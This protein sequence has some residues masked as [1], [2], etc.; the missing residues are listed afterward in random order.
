VSNDERDP[1]DAVLASEGERWRSAQATPPDPD[2][3]RLGAASGGPSR[4]TPVAAVAAVLAVIAAIG[5][6]AALNRG[7]AANP[8]SSASTT[9]ARPGPGT[10]VEG[11]GVLYRERG[12]PIR[13]CAGLVSTADGAMS[14]TGCIAPEVETTGV[15]PALLTTRAG[16]GADFSASV[17]VEGTHHKGVL[18]VTR[19]E[20]FQGDPGR[21]NSPL[22]CPAP[23]E[24]WK[25][26][27][28]HQPLTGQDDAI[29]QANEFVLAN[30]DRFSG[31][32]LTHPVIIPVGPGEPSK[33]AVVVG[34]TG[35]VDQVRDELLFY[36]G[37]LCVFKVRYSKADLDRLADQLRAVT[38]IPLTVDVDEVS[39]KVRVRTVVL[40]PAAMAVLDRF[41]PGALLVEEPLLRWLD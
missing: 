35:D 34:T 33:Q 5:V 37:N 4:W 24:G 18:A 40:D 11:H 9:P 25:P 26:G 10:P 1:I 29:T 32:W 39:D 22:P 36:N 7:R 3:A 13:L 19:V 2:L 16:S 17:R 31:L 23:A 15:D 20:P 14:G 28:G 21:V 38:E 27:F 30:P 8:G 6:P 41:D 12:G